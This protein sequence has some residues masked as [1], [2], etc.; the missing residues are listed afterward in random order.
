[1][2]D[3]YHPKPGAMGGRQFCGIISGPRALPYGDELPQPKSLFQRRCNRDAGGFISVRCYRSFIPRICILTR[4]RVEYTTSAPGEA[5]KRSPE[6]AYLSSSNKAPFG[7]KEALTVCNGDATSRR[8]AG[9]EVIINRV[10]QSALSGKHVAN[11][12]LRRFISRAIWI[13]KI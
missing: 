12:C 9:V 13:S 2:A 6:R 4:R 7:I 11:P 5:S 8:Y 10:R 1:M 3:S